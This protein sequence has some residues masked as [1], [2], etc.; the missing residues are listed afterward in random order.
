MS[1]SLSLST[2]FSSTAS[3]SP[4]QP[5][6]LSLS[7]SINLS[8]SSA[9]DAITNELLLLSLLVLVLVLLSLLLLPLVLVLVLVLL[10]ILGLQL[11]RRWLQ[12]STQRHSASHFVLFLFLV[13]LLFVCSRIVFINCW[14]MNYC[15]NKQA[16]S[17]MYPFVI[18]LEAILTLT[19]TSSVATVLI[20]IMMFG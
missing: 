2:S 7:L 4:T 5:L 9:M 15:T 16:P 18:Q 12:W 14:L 8:H 3:S 6:C 17:L 19:E 11:T 10:L 20:N 1:L 13:Y